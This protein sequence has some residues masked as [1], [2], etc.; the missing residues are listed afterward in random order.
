MKTEVFFDEDEDIVDIC[1]D[2]VF[3]AVFTKD[4]PQ[5]RGALSRLVSAL[6]GLNVTIT[7]I[8]ANELP[9]EGSW[10]R[11][12]R[13]DINCKTENGE[14]INVEMSLNP[15]T[16]EPV[17]MEY[18]AA[19]LFI[20]QNI[21]GSD[22]DYSDLKQSYQITILVNKRIF[23]DGEFYHAFEYYDPARR[24]SLN[25]RCKIVALELSKLKKIAEKPANDMSIQE[26]WAVF[27]RYLTDKKKR[28]KINEIIKQEEGIS[29]ASEA[30]MGF[31]QE[32]KEY[33]WKVKREMFELDR[34]SEITNARRKERKKIARKMKKLGDSDERIHAIT[35]LDMEIIKSL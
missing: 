4:I 27:F 29:M 5:S 14:L 2:D 30:I 11:Q 22:K 35:G 7:E 34:Q 26:K 18:H 20:R 8:L 13:Y 3:K 19:K 1:Y 15:D 24:V 10:D 25:G 28:S 17:R 23:P 12:T 16:L 6:I 21:K 9:V 33:L 32:E 31:T